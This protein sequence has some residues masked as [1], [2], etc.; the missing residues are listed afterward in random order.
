M[1]KTALVTGATS[2][3][4][5]ELAKLLAKDGYQLV[6]VARNKDELSKTSSFLQSENKCKTFTVA[7][8][9]SDPKAPRQLFDKVEELGLDV[10]VLVNNAGFGLYGPFLETNLD[11][12]LSMIRLNISALTELTKLFSKGMVKRKDGKILNLASTAAFEPGPLMAVY[13]AS[14]AYVLSFSQ[15]LSNE[16]SGTGVTVTALC[17]G[18]TDT[19]FKQRA[20]LKDA[21]LFS[22]LSMMRPEY[23]A[24]VGYEGMLSGQPVV[25]PGFRNRALNFLQRFLPRST[26]VAYVRRM[27][28]TRMDK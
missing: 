26:V 25:I 6:L 3:I 1:T 7:V 9:L 4:G 24:K 21:K 18:P 2:G 5:L 23:V 12:E 22:V 15:A 14:K 19:N 28:E 13:Y 16:L 10:D 11:Q 8:D 17:P 27:Q 20:G